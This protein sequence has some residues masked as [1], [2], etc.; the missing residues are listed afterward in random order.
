MTE[1]DKNE[2]RKEYYNVH[3]TDK[4]FTPSQIK[5]REEFFIRLDIARQLTIANDHQTI[6]SGE[7]VLLRSQL[8]RIANVLEGTSEYRAHLESMKPMQ[9]IKPKKE[10]P[11]P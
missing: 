6:A 7:L 4:A 9:D 2:L 3:R 8:T 11:N 5:E 10:T 1:D